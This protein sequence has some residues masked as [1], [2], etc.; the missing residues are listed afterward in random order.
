MIFNHYIHLEFEISTVK[1]LSFWLQSML[2]I[3]AKRGNCYGKKDLQLSSLIGGQPWVIGGDFNQTLHPFEHSQP[4][5]NHL[6]KEM[7][8]FRDCLI[9][10]EMFDLRF[11]GPFH[12][13][14]NNRPPGPITE[15]LDRLLV[16]H[17]WLSS[18]PNSV[19]SFSALEFSYH[20]PC[21]LDLACLLPTAKKKPFRF[22]N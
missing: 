4:G 15:K 13:W 11:W 9:Q 2:L 12:T 22:F 7:L 8:E 21:T 20:S 5:I 10:I 6:T 3:R 14:T 1:D 17:S 18:Y 16:S 19:A